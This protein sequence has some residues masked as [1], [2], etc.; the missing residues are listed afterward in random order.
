MIKAEDLRELLYEY[1]KRREVL[2]YCFNDIKSD[3]K[4][5]E[6][7]IKRRQAH[8]KMMLE[9]GKAHG[10]ELTPAEIEDYKRLKDKRSAKK[11]L[12]ETYENI[13][14][15]ETKLYDILETEDYDSYL[16]HIVFN[17]PLE[18]VA[19][20]LRQTVQGDFSS[21]MYALYRHVFRYCFYE[22][23]GITDERFR[24]SMNAIIYVGALE[25]FNDEE[26]NSYLDERGKKHPVLMRLN[27]IGESE[28]EFLR[29][30][31]LYND[32]NSRV[33][34][35]ADDEEEQDQQ[36][37]QP[38]TEEQSIGLNI[39][40]RVIYYAENLTIANTEIL[41]ILT[42][43]KFNADLTVFNKSEDTLNRLKHQDREILDY[44]VLTLYPNDIT[45]FSDYQIATGLYKEQT[46]ETVSDT[47][48][49]EINASIERLRDIKIDEGFISKEKIN[50]LNAKVEI[51]GNLIVLNRVKVKHETKATYW[52]IMT[53]PFYYDYAIRT[54]KVNT[55]PKQII[56]RG[57]EDVHIEHNIKND[58]LKMMLTRRVISLEYYKRTIVNVLEI[59]DVLGVTDPRKYTDARNKAKEMLE[60]L[61]KDYNF[62][63]TFKKKQRTVTQLII[64]RY[65]DRPLEKKKKNRLD[66]F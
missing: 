22:N 43:Q 46:S 29:I 58:T 14:T 50:D 45:V 3:I 61:Q 55:Y 65:A 2:E 42:T 60:D 48:L 44:I 13:G 66:T 16:K 25:T 41:N 34:K 47:M 28:E 37:E 8:A 18:D 59:Y 27:E 53:R 33:E 49:K 9:S 54:G 38:A 62:K 11:I 17:E 1:F 7:N 51:N 10:K 32:I 56:T 20:R 63:Y 23:S 19:E 5:S 64:D 4:P 12:T 36:A 35:L 26:F 21:V 57:I 30:A 6:E 39:A 15:F 40:P 31:S 24:G 52:Q